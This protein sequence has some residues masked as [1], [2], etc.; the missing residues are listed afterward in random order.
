[1]LIENREE[2]IDIEKNFLS[3]FTVINKIVEKYEMPILY[4]FHPRSGIKKLEF[5]L[6]A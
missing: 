5:Q 2:I 1:M 3:L 4:S 6:D